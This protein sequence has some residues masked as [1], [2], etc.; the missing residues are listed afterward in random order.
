MSN[1]KGFTEFLTSTSIGLIILTSIVSL[2]AQ[3]SI[4]SLKALVINKSMSSQSELFY[5]NY[6]GNIEYNTNVNDN[7]AAEEILQ[8]TGTK[9]KFFNNPPNPHVGYTLLI[10][11]LEIAFFVFVAYL[12]YLLLVKFGM[13][14]LIKEK[15]MPE[16]ETNAI[17]SSSK[18][19]EK[20]KMEET[21]N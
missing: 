9:A 18:F 3:D 12:I 10:I 16:N 4:S 7:Q 20:E 15:A 1:V 17:H 14:P 13:K 2:L 21:K 19:E 6:R 5:N 8:G 11:V